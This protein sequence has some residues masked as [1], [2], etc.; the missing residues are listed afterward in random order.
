MIS[1]PLHLHQARITTDDDFSSN[2]CALTVPTILRCRDSDFMSEHDFNLTST[3]SVVGRCIFC[4]SLLKP[5]GLLAVANAFALW[6]SDF[7]PADE[8][9]SHL[10]C[11]E[12]NLIISKIINLSNFI[13]QFS[14]V[15]QLC[16]ILYYYENFNC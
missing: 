3:Q 15:S 9:G 7:P 1:G 6:C 10:V 11:L 8:A 4:C 13:S 2:A 5:F 12:C 16:A 14:S